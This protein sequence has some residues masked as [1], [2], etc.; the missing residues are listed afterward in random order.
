MSEEKDVVLVPFDP[1]RAV[2]PG[3]QW[4]MLCD[5]E[6]TMW[7][8]DAKDEMIMITCL[9]CKGK[10]YWNAEDIRDYHAKAPEICKQTCG[11]EHREV[12]IRTWDE[13]MNFLE[14][15]KIFT[16]KLTQLL[17]EMRKDYALQ[18]KV[19]IQKLSEELSAHIKT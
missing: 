5:G 2:P 18:D 7:D 15:G 3:H 14:N 4:C 16:D 8:H 9:I 10:G 13:S 19:L 17:D 11:S 12:E 1:T 6:R